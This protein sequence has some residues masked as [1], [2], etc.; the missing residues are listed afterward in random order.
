MILRAG[1]LVVA[2]K[3]Q[4]AATAM[5]HEDIRTR[6]SDTIQDI[7]RGTGNWAYVV[8]VFGDDKSGDVV[9]S[10]SDDLKKASYTI[11][12]ANC[13]VDTATAV[14]V[15]PLTTYE[16]EAADTGVAES[17]ARNSKRDLMQLQTIHD[18]AA[19]LGANCSMKE[20]RAA[21]DGSIILRES[22]M[23]VD[24]VMLRESAG[25]SNYEIKLISPGAGS[26]AYYTP[27]VLRR[28]GP[29]AFPAETKVYLNH[30][31]PEFKDVGNRDVH[32][33]AGVLSE[34]ARWEDSH[35]KGPGL[36]SR[37]KV[38][39]DH[40]DLMGEKAPYLAMSIMANGTL[41]TEAGKPVKRDG[42]PV[43]ERLRPSLFNSVDVVPLAGAGGMILTESAKPA[44]ISTQEAAGMTEAE[45][46]KLIEAAVSAATAPLRERALRGDAR[47]E[48]ARLLESV[49]LPAAAKTRITERSIASLPT[50]ADGSLDSAKLRETVVAEAKAEGEYITSITGGTG[51]RGMG[52]AQVA[53]PKP[54]DIA[55]RE[56]REKSDLAED[57]ALYEA[58]GMDA[59]SAE[60][61]AKG[62]AA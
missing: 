6:L 54:E 7:F 37:V 10:C 41:A 30:T 18:S 9:Y 12:G 15:M 26:M 61:A 42:V 59:K 44:E 43:L 21:E 39:A 55:A 25:K 14:S 53:P 40:A 20:S 49:T 58:L 1:Y 29:V 13:K 56:A 52:I 19:A 34:A 17:G 50:T 48:C 22:A 45:A 3:I 51:V 62:R 57:I 60:F 28:D 31:P 32:R 2:T 35:A 27:E 23:Q 11:N 5:C 8:A 4:E 47:E 36:Y 38:F 46:K 33:L 16:V 24:T